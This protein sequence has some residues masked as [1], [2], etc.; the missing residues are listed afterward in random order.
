MIVASQVRSVWTASKTETYGAMSS[1]IGLTAL[2]LF[3][4]RNLTKGLSDRGAAGRANEILSHG[5]TT[6]SCLQF[7]RSRYKH[8]VR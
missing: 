7:A 4:I 2:E 3:V 5:K 6:E 8:R 1:R